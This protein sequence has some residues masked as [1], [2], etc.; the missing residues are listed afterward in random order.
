[1]L[2]TPTLTMRALRPP[3]VN[4]HDV[5]L[6][7]PSACDGGW[8]STPRSPLS[9]PTAPNAVV[10]LLKEPVRG[11]PSVC[12]MPS[13][14]PAILCSGL[15]PHSPSEAYRHFHFLCWGRPYRH[16]ESS[17]ASSPAYRLVGQAARRVAPGHR[18]RV[19]V[20]T[21]STMARTPYRALESSAVDA[22]H[23][24]EPPQF[25]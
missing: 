15:R 13:E 24:W 10:R 21:M 11:T 4:E 9:G 7:P 2:S 18:R 12:S 14:P 16:P 22:G 25:G 23:E 8:S 19:A 20:A 17:L 1:M 5:A 6:M 3:A